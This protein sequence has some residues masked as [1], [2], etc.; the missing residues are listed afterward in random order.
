MFSSLPERVNFYGPALKCH[1]QALQYNL[2]LCVSNDQPQ[3]KPEVFIGENSVIEASIQV[4]VLTP[5]TGVKIFIVSSLYYLCSAKISRNDLSGVFVDKRI[6][7]KKR[8]AISLK[9][10][11]CLNFTYD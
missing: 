1:A 5:S 11:P 8:G 10:N 9:K 4:V 6:T 7:I 2:K 3:L